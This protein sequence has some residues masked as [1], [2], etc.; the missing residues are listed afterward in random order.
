MGRSHT[1]A[2]DHRPLTVTV[3][4]SGVV[5][6]RP[7]LQDEISAGVGAGGA[8]DPDAAG[9]RSVPMRAVITTLDQGVAS[10]SNFAVGVA[11]A[12]ISGVAGLGAFSLAYAVW[13]FVASMHRSLV[14]E[15]HGYCRR[16]SAPD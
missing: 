11:V 16:P 10:C 4:P 3:G 2:R 1:H 13:L 9:T 7:I 15:S 5:L 14:T 6:F 8:N 12:R